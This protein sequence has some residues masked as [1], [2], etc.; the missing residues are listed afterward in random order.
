[1]HMFIKSPWQLLVLLW[2]QADSSFQQIEVHRWSII[3]NNMRASRW[4]GNI[5]TCRKLDFTKIYTTIINVILSLAISLAPYKCPS[6]FIIQNIIDDESFRRVQ[7][8]MTSSRPCVSSE[9]KLHHMYHP[10][11]LHL[12]QHELNRVASQ[13]NSKECTVYQETLTKRKFD[14]FD[15]FWSNHSK[16]HYYINLQSII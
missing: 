16:C 9:S 2:Q 3:K 15:E 13:V 6:V 8:Y 14:E 10:T 12:Q 5:K 11:L 7:F 1:M 4:Y